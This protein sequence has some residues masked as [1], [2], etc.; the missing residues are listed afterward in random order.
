MTRIILVRHGQTEWNRV[1]HYRGRADIPLNATGFTQAEVTGVRIALEWVGEIHAIYCSPLLRT[2]QTAEA[3]GNHVKLP[4][5][6]ISSLVDLNMGQWQGLTPDQ[7]RSRWPELF[8]LWHTSPN[9]VH[10]PD[11]ETLEEVRNRAMTGLHELIERHA[12]QTI[13]LVSHTDVNRVILLSVMGLGI[14]RLWAIRQDNCAVNVI[15]VANNASTLVTMNDTSHLHAW[16]GFFV[17]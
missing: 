3:I 17:L 11:G 4:V 5:S 8:S 13:V 10:F 7:V 2:L 1:E 16:A 14:E 6:C 12:G 9:S 15:E